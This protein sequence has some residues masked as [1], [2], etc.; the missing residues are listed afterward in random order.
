MGF[1]KLL[2]IIYG[3]IYSFKLVSNLLRVVTQRLTFFINLKVLAKNS[4]LLAI[5]T[6]P[7]WLFSWN[8]AR[9]P[10]F[11]VES[12]DTIY[13]VKLC[14]ALRK[15]DTYIFTSPLQWIK[16]PLIRIYRDVEIP[17]KPLII[18]DWIKMSYKA[19]QIIYLFIPDAQMY[20]IS[21]GNQ[22]TGISACEV[23][24]DGVIH[25]ATTFLSLLRQQ[26]EG[27]Q[28]YEAL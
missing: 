23:V 13:I 9:R 20:F 14:G 18:D 8:K 2:I 6:K 16:H 11:I 19:N 25:S 1:L 5:K 28:G 7:T 21:S 17:Q 15:T 12:L 24:H 22:L 4:S 27:S 26:E 10:S 3:S